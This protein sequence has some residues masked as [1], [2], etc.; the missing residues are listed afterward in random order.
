MGRILLLLPLRS[1]IFLLEKITVENYLQT[2]LNGDTLNNTGRVILTL[3]NRLHLRAYGPNYNLE[4]SEYFRSVMKT[5]GDVYFRF[6]FKTVKDFVD[7]LFVTCGKR[8][9]TMT[10]KN[11][12]NVMHDCQYY[13]CD[14]H[15]LTPPEGEKAFGEIHVAVPEAARDFNLPVEYKEIEG[16]S[17]H[18][19]LPVIHGPRE[20]LHPFYTNV[21]VIGL[22]CWDKGR[23]RP[24]EIKS[25]DDYLRYIPETLMVQHEPGVC[26]PQV[27]YDRDFHVR[28]LKIE[29]TD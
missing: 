21:A 3:I 23:S 19:T 5:E 2:L 28:Y 27:F 8:W 7:T 20:R 6:T 12:L 18:F 25:V 16:N 9:T 26:D 10:P 17:P 13:T 4:Q 22:H 24:A 11:F 14:L 29:Y 1:T 15:D